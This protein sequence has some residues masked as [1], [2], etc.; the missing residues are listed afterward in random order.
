MKRTRAEYLADA[1]MDAVR[2]SRLPQ[3]K[4]DEA[5]ARKIR[6]EYVYASRVN[7]APALARRYGLHRRT[8]EK[9]LTWETWTHV[10]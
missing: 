3:A 8:I 1:N 10:R 6:S 2:G 5:T 9:L 7:G 4:L